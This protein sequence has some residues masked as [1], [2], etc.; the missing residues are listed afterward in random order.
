[1]AMSPTTDQVLVNTN[2]VDQKLATQRRRSRHVQYPHQITARWAHRLDRLG[3]RQHRD[4]LDIVAGRLP[5]RGA[6]A[7]ALNM[8]AQNVHVLFVEGS[9]H[10]GFCAA[11]NASLDAA[12]ISQAVGKPVRVQYTASGRAQLRELR[13]LRTRGRLSGAVD[14]SGAKPKITVWDR[15]A[16][17][18][19][20]G[21]RPGPPGEH[22]E[23]DPARLPRAA[24]RSLAAADAEPG[25]EHASTTRTASPPTSSR[26][27]A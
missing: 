13:A 11:D 2:D 8:P 14:T 17:T 27:S 12:V 1:M 3:E 25:A 10:Y 24:L 20:R 22:A 6:L 5:L 4:G 19:A 18:S 16:W 23:R 21:N 26:A 9:G 7:T 15:T